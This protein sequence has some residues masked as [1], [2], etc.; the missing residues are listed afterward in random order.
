METFQEA[1]AQAREAAA[2][3]G[4]VVSVVEYQSGAFG[5]REGW[6]LH[7]LPEGTRITETIW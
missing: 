4:E 7:D 5:Y 3:T 1:L 2:A 6:P